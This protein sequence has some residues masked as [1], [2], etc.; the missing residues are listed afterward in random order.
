[1]SLS[2]DH[3]LIHC[4]NNAEEVGRLLDDLVNFGHAGASCWPY[5]CFRSGG[6]S[7]AA[8]PEW[9]DHR[10]GCF[11]VGADCLRMKVC[12]LRLPFQRVSA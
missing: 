5:V 6:R 12:C 1:M 9:S 11:K 10:Q 3:M 4:S 8:V 7:A 2:L